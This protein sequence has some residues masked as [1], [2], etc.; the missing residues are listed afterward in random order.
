MNFFTTDS[1]SCKPISTF[2]QLIK[3][4][5][6]TAQK[7]NTTSLN[8]VYYFTKDQAPKF[9]VCHD[10]KNNYLDD[11]FFQGSNS[12]TEY[13]FYHWNL[14]DSFIYFSHHFVT[15]PTESWINA[16]HENN[17]RILGTIITEFDQGETICSLIFENVDL[18][19]DKLV[20]ITCHYGFDGWL[21]NIENKVKQVEKL[22][23]F[24]KNL[25]EKL[26]KTN[27]K[28]YQVIWYDSVV[29]TGELK[30][31]NEL[32]ISNEHFFHM[33]DG[34]F[35]N[36]TWKDQNLKNS[37]DMAKERFRDVFVG[38]DVF[39]RGCHGNGGFNT[40]QAMEK[41]QNVDLSYALFAPG[42][43]HECNDVKKF[44]E[45][46]QKFWS[47][48]QKFTYKRKIKHLPIVSSF[49]HASGKNFFIQGCK[50]S[51]TWNNLNLQ[52]LLPVV[53]KSDWDFDDGFFGGSCL[54]LEA[55]AHSIF[56]LDLAVNSAKSFIFQLV[57]KTEGNV[58]INLD[59]DKTEMQLTGNSDQLIILKSFEKNIQ[60]WKSKKFIFK[61][62][63]DFL[64]KNIKLIGEKKVKLG[65]IRF[66]EEEEEEKESVIKKIKPNP[67][68][69][70]YSVMKLENNV[71]LLIQLYVSKLSW[72]FYNVLLNKNAGSSL[73]EDMNLS[74]V[75]S[76]KK[77]K[78][79]LC[80]KLTKN[81]FIDSTNESR[82]DELKIGILVHE[83]DNL[84]ENVVKNEQIFGSESVH[85]LNLNFPLLKLHNSNDM[86]FIE[87]VIYDMEFF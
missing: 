58:K 14:I 40:C 46:N 7:Y 75:G 56:D 8:P 62:K 33:T 6:D 23:Y 70:K 87:Q 31:Q 5:G 42:W 20:Q 68:E 79:S 11:K 67:I 77:N 82:N 55:G 27:D 3:W 48:L 24:V 73:K 44:F 21:I 71:Y 53:E 17:C 49:S 52:S 2:S 83:M 69:M 29:K 41:I 65:L 50:L 30:W 84:M 37:L 81:I 4:S 72:K 22:D 34:I 63:N 9:L 26:K 25:S 16:A 38:I 61:F 59:S 18:I 54:S 1:I 51:D 85:S 60:S 45:N 28:L 12:S 15:I 78:F 43:I 86:N 19:I 47:L 32:N 66:F 76:S 35:L 36:Y 57:F 74:Y 64:L 10:M 39:G 13:S 80:L